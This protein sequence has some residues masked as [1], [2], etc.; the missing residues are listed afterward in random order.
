MNLFDDILST[1]NGATI[2]LT[3]GFV[4][5]QP[6][7]SEDKPMIERRD[8]VFLAETRKLLQVENFPRDGQRYRYYPDDLHVIAQC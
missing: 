1:V 8:K 2:F 7:A 6:K 3:C 5:T 4:L